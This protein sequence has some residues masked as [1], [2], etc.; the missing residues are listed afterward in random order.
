MNRRYA[1]AA[2][3]LLSAMAC[4]AYAPGAVSL[5]GAQAQTASVPTTATAELKGADGKRLGTVTLTESARGVL[6]R[7][8]GRGMPPGLRG[9]H[10]HAKA[11]CSDAK[12]ERAGGHTHGG[13]KSV[14]GLLNPSATDTGDLPNINVAANGRA[15][16]E[17]FSTFV[18]LGGSSE[19]Q[20]LL[21][22]DGSAVIVHANADDHR[23]QP[24]G[25]AGA[26]IACGVITS[27]R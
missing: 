20:S 19:R 21:D 6:A 18:T 27:G 1:V 23:S 3:S 5:S 14:H 22:A 4:A 26:R 24:I 16:A 15:D 17:L 11:D 9:V 10:F 13:D 8:E 12:F 25:G 7:V 2:A